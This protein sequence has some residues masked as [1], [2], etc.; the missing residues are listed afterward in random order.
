MS[1]LKLDLKHA[2]IAYAIE[3]DML[4]QGYRMVNYVP[5]TGPYFSERPMASLGVLFA[6]PLLGRP[7]VSGLPLARHPNN[8]STAPPHAQAICAPRFQE[9]LQQAVLLPLST[10]VQPFQ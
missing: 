6:P 10:L 3:Q 2:A 1:R 4:E 5:G 7:A 9:E 8:R